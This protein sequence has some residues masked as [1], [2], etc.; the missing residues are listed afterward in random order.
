M[1]RLLTGIVVLGIAIVAL[2]LL[3]TPVR[4]EILARL[5][6]A[7]VAERLREVEGRVEPLWRHR[8]SGAEVS[9]IRRLT[10]IT[11][12]DERRLLVYAHGA[13]NS[14]LLAEYPVLAA[15]G[16]LGPKLREGDR[17]VPEGVY[18]ITF[19][20]P[21]SRYRLSMR[22]NYPNDADV[23]AARS[24]GRD[25]AG[26]GGDIMIHGSDKSVGC[27]A[28]GDAA[29]EEVFWLAAHVGI[30][31]VD[32]VITPDRRP[33]ERVTPHTPAWLG[34]RYLELS[35]RLSKFVLPQASN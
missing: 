7:T 28:I 3:I 21:N 10:L 15:S 19:L 16:G 29:I 9:A 26:L 31:N 27:V 13:S 18:A 35:Q 20:N 25:S 23:E 33:D 12:K 32:V 34:A 2:G 24:D 14:L 5:G 4:R 6:R 1:R 30:E 17:Q 11:I 22:L 8:L